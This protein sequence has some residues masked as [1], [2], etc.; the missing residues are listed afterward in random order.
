VD[1]EAQLGRLAAR[2][3]ALEDELAIHRLLVRYGFCADTGDAEAAASL[4]TEDAE[5]F[6]DGVVAGRGRDAARDVVNS[7]AHQAQLP[8]TTHEV[9]PFAVTVDGDTATATGYSFLHLREDE[10]YSVRRISFNRWEL[11]REAGGWLIASR[12]TA[13]LDGSERPHALLRRD[14]PAATP[15]SGGPLP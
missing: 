6:V 7:A 1:L 14:L 3:T 12:H 2:V 9:G 13:L 8:R 15:T 4:F 10:G 11:R 5:V